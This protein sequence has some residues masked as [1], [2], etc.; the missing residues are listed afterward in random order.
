MLAVAVDVSDLWQTVAAAFVAGIGVTTAFSLAILGVARFADARRDG[1][2]AVAIAF[3][4][5]AV[6]GLLVTFAA[7]GL[8][9]A[10]MASG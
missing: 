1:R 6:A 5:L 4:S 9:I 2:P 7:V 3:A 10:L 8:G